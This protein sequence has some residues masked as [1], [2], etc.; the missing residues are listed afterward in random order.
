MWMSSIRVTFD[1]TPKK[2]VQCTNFDIIDTLVRF[3]TFLISR[4][5]DVSFK[6]N[7]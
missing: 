2:K 7:V 4:D 6:S 3:G 1:I 5:V